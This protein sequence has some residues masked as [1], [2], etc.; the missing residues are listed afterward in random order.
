[1]EKK[2]VILY[3]EDD[4]DDIELLQDALSTN[5]VNF[6]MKVIMDGKEAIDYLRQCASFPSIIVLDY[7]LPKVHGR[8]ILKEIRSLS[9]LKHLPVLVLTTSS[10]QM[11]MNTAMENGASRYMIKPTTMAGIKN[12]V[13]SIVEL[14]V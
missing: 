8:E 11:D 14:A 13:Q 2:I 4:P 12:T 5:K 10:N 1:M 9:T 6:E 7:N 3:I